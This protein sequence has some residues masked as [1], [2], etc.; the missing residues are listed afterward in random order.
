MVIVGYHQEAFAGSEERR[1]AFFMKCKGALRI[2]AVFYRRTS[3]YTSII[4]AEAI[5]SIDYTRTLNNQSNVQNT[6][7]CSQ[8]KPTFYISIRTQYH[9]KINIWSRIS[10]NKNIIGSFETE[11]NLNFL[12]VTTVGP[13][14]E[15]ARKNH[16]IYSQ[17]DI[18]SMHFNLDDRFFYNSF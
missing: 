13:L 1:S 18:C 2:I 7:D 12:L 16:E 3:I 17:Q 9:P 6:W 5:L 11:E 15:I 8:K 14:L 10:S 4:D